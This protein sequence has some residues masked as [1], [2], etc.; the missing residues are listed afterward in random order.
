MPLSSL[1]HLDVYLNIRQLIFKFT[2]QGWQSDDVHNKAVTITVTV[3][4]TIT[5][6]TV[7]VTVTFL[8]TK[9]E[10]QGSN[11]RLSK[12]TRFSQ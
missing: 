8:P 10:N 9:Y 5:I 6:V 11:S 2:G 12:L 7:T 3:T 1:H 4:N